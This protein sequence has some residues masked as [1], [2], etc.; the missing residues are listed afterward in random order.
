MAIAW[1]VPGLEA[2]PMPITGAQRVSDSLDRARLAVAGASR[3]LTVAVAHA[4]PV[5]GLVLVPLIARAA[6]LAHDIEAL[7]RARARG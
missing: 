2:P 5:E 7:K 6:E 1:P 3:E 4:T